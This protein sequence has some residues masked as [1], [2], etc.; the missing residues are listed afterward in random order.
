MNFLKK[1]LK[2][3]CI[4]VAIIIPGIIL[5]G[6]AALF[7][8]D[9]HHFK[10]QLIR[11]AEQKLGR[12]LVIDGDFS[13]Q[14]YP[15]IAIKLTQ[16]HLKNPDS[17][18]AL[19]NNDFAYANSARLKIELLPLL[20][21]KV[22]IEELE[23]DG[24][25]LTL[26]RIAANQDNWSDLVTHFK[27]TPDGKEIDKNA[28]DNDD[29]SGNLAKGEFKLNLAE[30]TIHQAELTYEDK[31]AYKNYQL[32]NLNFYTKKFAPNH[33]ADIK[34][35]FIFVAG[36]ITT[37]MA[38]AGQMKFNPKESQFELNSLT[39]K[40]TLLSNKLPSGQFVSD[41]SGTLKADWKNQLFNL[42]NLTLKFNES[43]AKGSAKLDFSKGLSARFNLGINTLQIDNYLPDTHLMLKNIETQGVFSN[44]ILTLSMLKA[45]L[46]QGNFQ[47]SSKITFKQQNMYQINGKFSGVDIQALLSSLKNINKISGTTNATLDLST[48]GKNGNEL[49]RNLNG[50][51]ALALH[52]GYLYGF[53]IEYYLNKAQVLTKRLPSD[54]PLTDNKKT[55]FDQLT[56]NFIFQNGVISNQDLQGRAN[57]YELTGAGT[58]DLIKEQIDYRLKAI[59]LRTDGSKRKMPLAI[60]I[61]GPLSHPKIQPDMETYIQTF[62]QDQLEKQI[63]KQLEK[64][65]GI[66]LDNGNNDGSNSSIDKKALQKELINKGLQKLFGK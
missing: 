56:G 17:F 42:Q 12:K 26:T 10:P 5:A 7:L 33:P 38:Y 48:A 31:P 66:T 30:T 3:S 9:S 15:S 53:D 65:L 39:L 45:N 36:A 22:Q 52:Q 58:I 37:K 51:I 59:T 64:K 57:I 32:K 55:P 43:V 28:Q 21:G 29:E 4:L 14:F 16:A 1:I 50:K 6:I 41:M 34:G 40:S 2:L 23:L 25:K 11:V 44:Q 63:N 35:N 18:E 61:T 47:G 49:K 60:L 24:L 62:A 8:V 54:T 20:K 46:Y 19:K 13:L 27:K